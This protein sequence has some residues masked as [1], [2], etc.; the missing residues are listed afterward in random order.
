MHGWSFCMASGESV[1]PGRATV[2][3]VSLCGDR[4][5]I[6]TAPLEASG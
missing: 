3:P 1:R 5:A 4:I 2:Y 6:E